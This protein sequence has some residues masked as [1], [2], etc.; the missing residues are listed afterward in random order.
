MDRNLSTDVFLHIGTFLE[1]APKEIQKFIF[2]HHPNTDVMNSN[3]ITC[4]SGT[5]DNSQDDQSYKTHF[6]SSEMQKILDYLQRKL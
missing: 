2:L 3:A 1:G 4:V 6:A 5:E